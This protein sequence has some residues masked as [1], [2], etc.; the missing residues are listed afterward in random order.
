MIRPLMHFL[1]PLSLICMGASSPAQKESAAPLPAQGPLVVPAGDRILLRLPNPLSTKGA[2]KGDQIE[3]RM[4]HDLFLGNQMVL[5][6]GLIILATVTQ[7]H[8]RR[9]ITALDRPELNLRLNHVVLPDGSRIPFSAKFLRAGRIELK[10]S[11][12]GE[13]ELRGP[14]PGKWDV[15]SA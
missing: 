9:P 6:R 15:A 5:P 14:G 8:R 2:R 11:A 10:P 3:L 13:V 7:S 1:F 4:V 12:T